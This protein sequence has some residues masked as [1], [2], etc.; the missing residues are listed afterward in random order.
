MYVSQ[1]VLTCMCRCGQLCMQV[2]ARRGHLVFSYP[3]EAGSPTELGAHWKLA[4]P[5]SSLKL[6]LWVCT[7]KMPSLLSLC[8][9]PNSGHHDCEINTLLAK[10]RLHSQYLLLSHTIS[11]SDWKP[12]TPC[13]SSQCSHSEYISFSFSIFSTILAPLIGFLWVAESGLLGHRLWP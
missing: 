1:W 6:E 2:E 3:S 7:Y 4:K 11:I 12:V 13:L 9:D 10:L 5:K 8:S